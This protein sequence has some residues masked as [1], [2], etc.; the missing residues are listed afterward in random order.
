MDGIYVE[1]NNYVASLLPTKNLASFKSAPQYRGMLEHVDAAIG[2]QYLEE[3]K[4]ASIPLEKVKEFC[5]LNDRIGS[6]I[7]SSYEIGDVSPSSLRYV[8]HAHLILTHFREKSGGEPIDIVEVGGGYGGLALAIS[9]FSPLYGVRVNSYSIVDLPIIS[10]FQRLYLEQHQLN[11]PVYHYPSTSYGGHIE[12]DSLYL[13]S[14]YCFSELSEALRN[15][16]EAI[17]FPKVIHGFI[18]WNNISLYDFGKVYTSEEEYPK[19]G[20]HNKYVRF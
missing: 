6:T 18:A 2:A 4:K 10:Q 9:F 8:F 13:I 19:T 17:L 5:E 16:Y 14:N 3:A 15:Q 1:Y 20:A 11:F 7:K 12:S